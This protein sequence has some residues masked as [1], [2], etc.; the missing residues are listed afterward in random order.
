MSYYYPKRILHGVYPFNV[1]EVGLLALV[2]IYVAAPI[3][4]SVISGTRSTWRS[5]ERSLQDKLAKRPYWRFYQANKVWPPAA[6]KV[7]ILYLCHGRTHGL[8]E[9]SH[10]KQVDFRASETYL[11]DADRMC[12]PDQQ[13]DLT[14][15][16]ALAD[17]VDGSIDLV[18]FPFCSCHTFPIVARPGFAA[19]IARVL[20][21][22]SGRMIIDNCKTGLKKPLTKQVEAALQGMFIACESFEPTSCRAFRQEPESLLLSSHAQLFR[23]MTAPEQREA[24]LAATVVPDHSPRA[25]ASPSMRSRSRSQSVSVSRRRC[26]RESSSE[27]ESE[28]ESEDDDNDPV[29]LDGSFV[30]QP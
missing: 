4:R 2:G 14:R 27:D 5:W 7:N 6:D 29:L 15:D 17:V 20:R 3:V 23:R 10:E 11:I 13:R 9:A 18:L 19:E 22:G 24:E 26:P 21:P 12:K 25:A 8:G 1:T 28:N 16:D 30:Q